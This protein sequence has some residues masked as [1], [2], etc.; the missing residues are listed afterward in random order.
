ML[1]LVSTVSGCV[2]VSEF[3]SLVCAPVHITSSA[4]GLGVCAITVGIKNIS[5]LSRKRRKSMIK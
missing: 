3:A 4:V 2:S 1:I 5:Q